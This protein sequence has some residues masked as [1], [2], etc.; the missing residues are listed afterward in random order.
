MMNFN[1]LAKRRIF[2]YS[3]LGL[4][5]YGT[6][7]AHDESSSDGPSGTLYNRNH[8]RITVFESQLD[9]SKIPLQVLQYKTEK[10]IP[11]S[12]MLVVFDVDGTLT[13]K[14]NPES[15]G[16]I[17]A[18]GGAVALVRLLKNLGVKVVSSSAWDD[19]GE[20]I[21]RLDNLGLSKDLGLRGEKKFKARDLYFDM[22]SHK[23]TQKKPKK[24]EAQ[25]VT[26]VQQ[27]NVAS[28]KTEGQYFRNKAIAP[29]TI[30]SARKLD[31]DV[32]A[33]FFIDD[34]EANIETFISDVKQYNLYRKAK[35]IDVLPLYSSDVMKATGLNAIMQSWTKPKVKPIYL[36]NRTFTDY[37]G[38]RTS[39]YRYN[40]THHNCFGPSLSANLIKQAE[41]NFGS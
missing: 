33:V 31:K 4:A 6:A 39:K 13:N 8:E 36:P 29:Y 32:K 19:F 20:T 11:Y 1:L 21:K 10:K 7:F 30:Y 41:L 26:I 37:R 35:Y 16:G 15:P 2:A 17:E 38:E 18:R 28:V 27:G 12:K 23:L 22:K 9:A 34:S 24:K 40:Q 25:P 14:S 3:L 5:F